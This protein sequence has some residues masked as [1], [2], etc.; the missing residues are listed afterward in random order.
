MKETKSLLST[1]PPDESEVMFESEDYDIKA[2]EEGRRYID[3]LRLV[4]G[5]PPS[6][7]SLR[8]NKYPT[9]WGT[10]YEVVVDYD[11]EDPFGRHYALACVDEGPLTWGDTEP[12]D[13]RSH[14][15]L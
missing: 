1:S 3:L 6:G 10:A 2:R 12:F 5:P 15:G 13:W 8:L 4:M 14:Y 9:D 11:T 7:C